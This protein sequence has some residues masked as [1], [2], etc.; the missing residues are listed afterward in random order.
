MRLCVGCSGGSSGE[1]REPNPLFLD[2]TEARKFFFLRLGPRL[3]S[4]S[5]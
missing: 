4:G 1:A 3:I 2:Q 5:G